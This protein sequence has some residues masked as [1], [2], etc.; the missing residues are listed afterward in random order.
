MAKVLR[1]LMTDSLNKRR[2]MTNI[3]PT[4]PICENGSLAR[5]IRTHTGEQPF[6]C[7]TCT[8]SFSQKGNLDRRMR[9]HTGEQPFKCTTCTKSFSQKATWLGILCGLIP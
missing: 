5:H 6:K 9:T 3:G 2:S 7:T 4:C 8:K 1:P